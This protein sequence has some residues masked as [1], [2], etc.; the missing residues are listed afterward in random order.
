[1]DEIGAFPSEQLP[2][3]VNRPKLDQRIQSHL[4]GG[5]MGVAYAEVSESSVN[6]PLW[7]GRHDLEPSSLKCLHEIEA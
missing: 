7:G 1:M 6:I 4:A 2:Q 5:E 3:A